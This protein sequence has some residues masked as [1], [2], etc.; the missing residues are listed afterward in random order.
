M[1]NNLSFEN[2]NSKLWNRT[3]FLPIWKSRRALFKRRQPGKEAWIGCG[4]NQTVAS[5]NIVTCFTSRLLS[6]GLCVN[7][8]NL[9]VDALVWRVECSR[10]WLCAKYFIVCVVLIKI[11]WPSHPFVSKR[12]FIFDNSFCFVKQFCLFLFCLTKFLPCGMSKSVPPPG[13][14]LTIII[15]FWL[16]LW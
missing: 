2:K 3:P 10:T 5:I 14:E 7:Y 13:K 16:F 12:N 9:M 15:S 6:R 1:W 4:A 11:S 8:R